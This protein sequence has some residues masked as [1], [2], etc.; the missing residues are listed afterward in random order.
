MEIK[1]Q[2]QEKINSKAE[3]PETLILDCSILQTVRNECMLFKPPRL[4]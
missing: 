4:Q 2:L 1:K 3:L